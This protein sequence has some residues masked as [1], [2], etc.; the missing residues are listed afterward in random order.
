M[1][2]STES[3]PRSALMRVMDAI[4]R[5]I[6]GVEIVALVVSC[7]ALFTIMILVFFDAVLRY[8]LNSPLVF[9]ADV[10]TLYLISCALLLVLSYT[11]R[12]GGHI[13]VDLFVHI[14]PTRLYDLLMAVALLL[15]FLVVGV[16]AY[17]V[18]ALTW[19]SWQQNEVMVGIYAWPL[20]LGKGI[21]A[22]S[23]V[24]LAVRLLHIALTHLIAGVTGNPR[25]A[26]PVTHIEDQPLEDAV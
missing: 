25:L 23:L 2:G 17:Q 21:V 3:K 9:T 8:T 5:A 14:L 11:L 13:N 10:V 15:A 7:V 22:F 20:W 19:E 18:A 4:D 16:M 26:I 24:I 6:G 1:P 12:Q